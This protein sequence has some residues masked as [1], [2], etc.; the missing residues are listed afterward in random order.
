MLF[1]SVSKMTVKKALDLLVAEGLIVKRRGSGTFIKDITE[2]EIH[3]IIDKKQFSGL[4]NNNLGHKV[5]SKILEFKVVPSDLEVANNLKIEEGDFVYFIHRVSV[6]I[7][8]LTATDVGS[9]I[10]NL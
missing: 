10:F 3:G 6:S 9:S 4:T 7:C 2:K 8:S 1:R 5:T